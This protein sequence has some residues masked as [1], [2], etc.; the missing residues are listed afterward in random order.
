M[1]PLRSLLLKKSALRD[2]QHSK[3][4]HTAS[5]GRNVSTANVTPVKGARRSARLFFAKL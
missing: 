5:V 4:S 1:H 2:I 3:D